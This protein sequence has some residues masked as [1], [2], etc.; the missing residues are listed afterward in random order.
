MCGGPLYSIE[1]S[2]PSE[3]YKKFYVVKIS[4]YSEASV[5]VHPYQQKKIYRRELVPVKK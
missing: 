1:F 5:V 4:E 2:I 3:I